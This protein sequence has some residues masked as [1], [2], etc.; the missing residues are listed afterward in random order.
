MALTGSRTI[1]VG[2]LRCEWAVRS[3]YGKDRYNLGWTPATLLLT[4]RVEGDPVTHQLRCESKHWT[5]A[6]TEDWADGNGVTAP[7]KVVRQVIESGLAAC[8]LVDW[9]VGPANRF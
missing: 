9:T 7:H 4:V 2:G 3:A 1:V 6:H 5:A 8:D